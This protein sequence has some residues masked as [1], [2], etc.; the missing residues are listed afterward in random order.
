MWKDV[1]ATIVRHTERLSGTGETVGSGC[2]PR[3]GTVLTWAESHSKWRQTSRKTNESPAPISTMCSP[4]TEGEAFD[5][6]N[7]VLG[8]DCVRG[9]SVGLQR[10]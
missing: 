9:G 3:P 6:V 7:N 5:I 1:V 10:C 4:K 8:Q 2:A